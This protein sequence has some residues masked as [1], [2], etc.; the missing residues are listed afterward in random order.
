MIPILALLLVLL[1][2]GAAQAHA[3]SVSYTTMLLDPGAAGASVRLRLSWLDA[4]V[5]EQ[6]GHR[7]EGGALL[8]FV[9]TAVRL[10]TDLGP[11]AVDS[12]P[13]E[14]PAEEGWLDLDW[15]V[16]CPVAA[17][18]RSSASPDKGPST[19]RIQSDLL[20]DQNPTHLSFLRVVRPGEPDITGV[21]D[22]HAR[23]V[24]LPVAGSPSG[25]PSTAAA[26]T[27]PPGSDTASPAAAASPLSR[28]VRLGIDHIASGWDHLLFLAM[29]V[30]GTATLRRTA[31]VITG[32]SIGHS[33]TLS[34]TVLGLVAPRESPVEA[35]IGLSI[36][37]VAIEN[38]WI[39]RRREDLWT[40]R[41]TVT[42]VL[43]VAIAVALLARP[44]ALAFAGVALFAACSFAWQ[45]RSA[46]PERLRALI[47]AL[48]GLVHGFG[49]ARALAPLHL[50]RADTGKSLFGFNLGVEIGQLAFVL[51]MWPVVVWLRG[52]PERGASLRYA[53]ALA[54]AVGAYL[55]VARALA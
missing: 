14:T 11:C 23:E 31:A 3:R 12:P 9:A 24:P 51:L 55:F 15:H 39:S 33:L 21:L 52:R 26:N 40:P 28:F 45:R 49:F 19:L 10:G 44:G 34:L 47:A 17:P 36:A 16:R 41:L 32:F 4:G 53:S 5:L 42:T 7:R 43:A 35:L 29:I 48:F 2:P 18:A 38:A 37:L 50:S 46:H 1:Y 6:A 20:F 30:L 13:H 22:T 8:D 54:V 25:D 27:A